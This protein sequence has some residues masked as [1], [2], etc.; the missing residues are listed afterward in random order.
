MR[1]FEHI[2]IEIVIRKNSAS[3]GCD[4]NGLSPEFHGVYAFGYKP[5]KQAVT[6]SRA[7]PEWG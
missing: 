6:A 3:H 5:L 7:V 2:E 4:A 1:G